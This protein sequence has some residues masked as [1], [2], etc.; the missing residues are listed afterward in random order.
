MQPV[1]IHLAVFNRAWKLDQ[2]QQATP[3]L[4]SHDISLYEVSLQKAF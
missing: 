2:G 4:S 1:D 3:V